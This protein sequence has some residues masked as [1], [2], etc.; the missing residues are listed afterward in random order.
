MLSWTPFKMG[1]IEE[2]VEEGSGGTGKMWPGLLWKG[3]S[4]SAPPHI[5]LPWCYCKLKVACSTPQLSLR[6]GRGMGICRHGDGGDLII[7][8]SAAQCSVTL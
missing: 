5:P 3:G 1:G 6:E 7:A 4:E 8:S 2:G